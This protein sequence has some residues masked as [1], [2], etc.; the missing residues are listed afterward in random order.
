MFEVILSLLGAMLTLDGY[1]EQ[2]ADTFRTFEELVI[3]AGF[4]LE[5]HFVTTEDSYVNRMFRVTDPTWKQAYKGV[6]YLQHGFT[7]SADNFVINVKEKAPAFVLASEGYDVYLGNLRGNYYSQG[8]LLYEAAT[9]VRYWE[10]ASLYKQGLDIQSFVEAALKISGFDK[11]SVISHSFGSVQMAINL[12]EDPEFYDERVNLWVLLGAQ[13]RPV[14]VNSVLLN[15]MDI[16]EWFNPMRIMM[17]WYSIQSD[18]GLYKNLFVLLSHYFHPG[19]MAIMQANSHAT[20]EYD[21]LDRFQVF[22]NHF[23]KGTSLFNN[24]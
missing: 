18:D 2:P 8:H 23:P 22:F 9:D 12:S 10:D 3:N 21:D 16:Y 5:T 15:L 14:E 1:M 20:F 11:L 4:E 17:Q 24:P 7:D 19:A 6:V 13:I